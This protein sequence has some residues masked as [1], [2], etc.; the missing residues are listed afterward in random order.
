MLPSPIPKNDVNR[1][2]QDSIIDHMPGVWNRKSALSTTQGRRANTRSRLNQGKSALDPFAHQPCAER[3]LFSD[4][5]ERCVICLK[6]AASPFKRL[7][8]GAVHARTRS[9]CSPCV[10]L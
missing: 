3:I 6:R 7:A 2:T 1:M 9:A 5:R 4:A 10:V 8:Y